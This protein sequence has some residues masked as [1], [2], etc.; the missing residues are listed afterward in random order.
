MTRVWATGNPFRS[1]INP[2]GAGIVN[3]DAAACRCV[4]QLGF[5]TEEALGLA[6]GSWAVDREVRLRN[7]AQLD[8]R[9]IMKRLRQH[10]SWFGAN[11]FPSGTA[12]DNEPQRFKK[13]RIVSANLSLIPAILAI[14]SADDFRKRS[15]EPNFLSKACFRFSLMP[16]HSS[17]TLSAIRFLSNS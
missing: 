15:T 12:N 8:S 9:G 14:S 4:S 17:S 13:R 11:L 10:R 5:M 7:K 2:R 3:Q 6:L 1:V 16:G